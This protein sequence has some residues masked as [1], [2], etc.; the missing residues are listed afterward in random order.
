V[1][2]DRATGQTLSAYAGTIDYRVPFAN[3]ENDRIYLAANNGMLVCL[4]D[5]DYATPFWHVR[6]AAGPTDPRTAELEAKLAKPITDAGQEQ[7][8]L[9]TLLQTL[10]GEK[11]GNV[12]YLLSENAFKEAGVTGIEDKLVFLPRVN[13]V[14]LGDVLKRVLDQVNATY[15]I[16]GDTVL[17]YP[18]PPSKKAVP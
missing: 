11:Y 13:K 4:H 3:T 6:S 10:L 8:K 16:V 5:R 15:R 9:G 7:T 18:A 17:I 14:P 2:L 1:V 12:K